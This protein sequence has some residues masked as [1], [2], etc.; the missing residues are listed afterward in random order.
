M[1]NA[2]FGTKITPFEP[3]LELDHQ[4]L[5]HQLQCFERIKE[6]SYMG[7]LTVIIGEPGTGKT[8]LKQALF[9]LPQKQW[10][11]IA[12]NRS[13]HSWNSFLSLLCQ[14][15]ELP[16]KGTSP[17]LEKAAVARAR[18]LNREGKRL[19]F[20][21]DD[22]QLLPGDLLKKIRLLLEDFPK[23]H[24]LVLIGQ[25]ELLKM[26]Q[27]SDHQDIKS[28]ITQS[29]DF[30]PLSP[31]STRDFIHHNLDR[32]GLPHNTFTTEAINLICKV[33]LGNLRAVKNL[34]IG[35]MVEAIRSQTRTVDHEHVNRVLDQPHW[36]QSNRLEG[37]EPV[38]FTNQR[39]DYKSKD[40]TS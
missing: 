29:A 40:L 13:I 2:Y 20:I 18:Q 12:I 8:L 3:E 31:E 21:I 36:R 26:L 6:Q 22:A 23:N 35:A 16:D 7:G 24:N 25:P 34:A 28:R 9:K 38:V 27:R 5:P 33:A 37:I 14:T 15:L 19:I 39:P 10:H 32:C 4:L 11:L 17:T 30:K 1:I